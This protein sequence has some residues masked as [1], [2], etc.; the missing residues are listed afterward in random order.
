MKSTKFRHTNEPHVYQ[1]WSHRKLRGYVTYIENL[2]INLVS[3][4]VNGSTVYKQ[5]R[6]GWRADSPDG[7]P[8]HTY[9]CDGGF[10]YVFETRRKATIR[11]LTDN[12]FNAKVKL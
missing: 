11:L 12:R 4:Y 2:G 6:G 3:T 7:T 8:I 10:G 1:V 5:L 9:N